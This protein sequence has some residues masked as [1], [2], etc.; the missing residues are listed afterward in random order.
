MPRDLYINLEYNMQTCKAV[1]TSTNVK[2]EHIN[3]L[4]DN[5]LIGQIGRGEDKRKPLKGKN[6]ISN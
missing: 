5:W 4:F 2:E 3:E 1:I 6:I